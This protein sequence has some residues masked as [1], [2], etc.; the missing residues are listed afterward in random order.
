MRKKIGWMIC[1]V[2]I[3]FVS[4]V[5][6][7]NEYSVKERSD[8]EEIIW[9]RETADHTEYLTFYSEGTFSY[10]Y[11]CGEPVNDSDLC[12]GYTYDK[13]TK[14]IRL[15]CEKPLDSTVTEIK[16]VSCDK[17]QLKLDFD[18]EIRTFAKEE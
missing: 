15:Q 18:G 3:A 16:V 17:E 2:V 4:T 8:F 6:A 13:K 14:T 7:G 1:I 11:E 10:H 5:Y 9:T 12:E